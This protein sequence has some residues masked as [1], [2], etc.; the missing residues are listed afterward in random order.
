MLKA[1]KIA[2][3]MTWINESPW[4]Y[5]W[6]ITENCLLWPEFRVKIQG[7]TQIIWYLCRLNHFNVVFFSL[8]ESLCVVSRTYCVKIGS[9]G[10]AVQTLLMLLKI[11]KLTLIWFYVPSE[12]SHRKFNFRFVENLIYVKLFS[13]SL[14]LSVLFGWERQKT[15]VECTGLWI[16]CYFVRFVIG[17]RTVVAV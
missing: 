9:F 2:N 5:S 3:R 7:N 16:K 14:S 17:R 10:I 11:L 1:T 8:W 12:F 4:V 15:R 6:K 13:P